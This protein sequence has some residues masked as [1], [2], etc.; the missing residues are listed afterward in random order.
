MFKIQNE[1]IKKM[2]SR[3][4]EHNNL[5]KHQ[6]KFYSEVQKRKI[7][8]HQKY[9]C[10]G[11]LCESLKILPSEW[12]ADHKIPI[13]EGG[14]NFYNFDDSN[15][16]TNNIQIIC[17]NCHAYKSSKE[18]V[19]FYALERRHKF[20]DVKFVLAHDFYHNDESSLNND[21]DND[22]LIINNDIDNDKMVNQNETIKK[23]QKI[24]CFNKFKYKR[25]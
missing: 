22:K 3:W 21:I 17:S 10:V 12:E 11:E 7:A 25:K 6:R 18:Q 5:L 2:L 14:S 20:A 4:N 24:F 8:Y 23:E 19:E 13:F 15:D 1:L 9:L 16:P